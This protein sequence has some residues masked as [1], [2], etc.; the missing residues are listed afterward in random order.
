MAIVTKSAPLTVV[1]AADENCCV[2]SDERGWAFV[3]EERDPQT[4]LRRPPDFSPGFSVPQ[5][6]G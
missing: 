6:D 2:L 5:G 1:S 4:G 3:L